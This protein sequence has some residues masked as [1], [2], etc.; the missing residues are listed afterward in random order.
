MS[1]LNTL[2]SVEI[3][4]DKIR[5]AATRVDDELIVYLLDMAILAVK[6]KAVSECGGFEEE[7]RKVMN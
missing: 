3:E 2:E 1:M 7:R 5:K 4:L 6:R